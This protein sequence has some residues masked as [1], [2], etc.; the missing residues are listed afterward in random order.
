LYGG[1]GG[2]GGNANGSTVNCP[3]GQPGGVGVIV[4]T[5]TPITAQPGLLNL[6]GVGL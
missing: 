5:Y 1:G 6:L 3:G 2:A 4:I